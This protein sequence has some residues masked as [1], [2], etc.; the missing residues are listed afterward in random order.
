MPHTDTALH[1]RKAVQA[2]DL[3]TTDEDNIIRYFLDRYDIDL[4][5]EPEGALRLY[6]ETELEGGDPVLLFESAQRAD[7]FLASFTPEELAVQDMEA[8]SIAM[9]GDH[10]L[11]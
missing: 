6:V 11:M 4:S 3:L 8:L 10:T 7:S 2:E 1:T 5:G 9:S